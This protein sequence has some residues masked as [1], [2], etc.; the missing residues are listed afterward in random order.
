MTNPFYDEILIDHNNHPI[1]K[2]DL[3]CP[4]YRCDG[5]NPSCGD[6]ITIQLNIK[7]GVITDG[8]FTGSGCAISQASADI[9]LELLIGKTVEEAKKL[10]ELFA[11]MIK[12][13]VTDE[14]L[15]TLD[16]ASVLKDISHMPARVK[17]AM[18]G[19]RT[20]NEILSENGEEK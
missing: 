17:C 15:E 8:S 5:V 1:H 4:D 13:E 14:E 12:G 18:L 3:D 11:R 6:E 2:H 7:D 16:E 9:M 19:W 20:I 10:S